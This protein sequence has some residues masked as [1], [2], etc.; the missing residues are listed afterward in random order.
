M[1]K[2]VQRNIKL[3]TLTVGEQHHPVQIIETPF[4]E[5]VELRCTVNGE[6]ITIGDR[7]LGEHEA[8]RLL[9]EEIRKRML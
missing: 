5:G 2:F 8:F 3:R 4:R 1:A 6:A 9:E 7:Q